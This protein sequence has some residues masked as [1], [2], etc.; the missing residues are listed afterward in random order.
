MQQLSGD[1]LVK[2]YGV[3]GGIMDYDEESG[4][5]HVWTDN[6][7]GVSSGWFKREDLE[8][9]GKCRPWW[10]RLADWLAFRVMDL[11]AR[12]DREVWTARRLDWSRSK[13]SRL[14]IM[15][16]EQWTAFYH[17]GWLPLRHGGRQAI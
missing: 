1:V 16:V 13:G 9:V 3:V 7:G 5:Y 14:N 15:T 11:A 10:D 2:P 4:L 17:D 8:P 6:F 12:L